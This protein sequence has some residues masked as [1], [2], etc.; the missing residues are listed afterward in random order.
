MCDVAQN[1]RRSSLNGIGRRIEVGA[2]NAAVQVAPWRARHELPIA[3]EQF[4]GRVRQALLKLGAIGLG[5]GRFSIRKGG[6]D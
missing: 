3:A 1:G 2:C 4:T 5:S 6:R